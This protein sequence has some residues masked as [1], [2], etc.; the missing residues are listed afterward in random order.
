M[1]NFLILFLFVTLIIFVKKYHVM[2]IR[3]IV[4]VALIVS[5][6]TYIYFLLVSKENIEKCFTT[7]D[8][9]IFNL[10]KN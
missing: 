2:Q 5:I 3:Y 1:L 8:C 10:L 6:Y 9:L 4:F 7:H